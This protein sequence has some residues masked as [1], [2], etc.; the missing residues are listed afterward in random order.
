MMVGYA[1]PKNVAKAVNTRAI[2]VRTLE[3]ALDPFWFP[4][5]LLGD[6]GWLDPVFTG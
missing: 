1:M 6:G 3:D 4:L 2:L 5:L